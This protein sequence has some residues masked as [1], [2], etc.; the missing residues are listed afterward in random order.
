MGPHISRTLMRVSRVMH[1]ARQALLG[2]VELSTGFRRN[3]NLARRD[4]SG[5]VVARLFRRRRKIPYDEFSYW[6]TLS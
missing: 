5:V 4:A 6:P 1:R 3:L 2:Q